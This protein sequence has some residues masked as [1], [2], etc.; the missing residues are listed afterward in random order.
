MPG[1]ALRIYIYIIHIERNKKV[2][3]YTYIT[4]IL[5]IYITYINVLHTKRGIGRYFNTFNHGCSKQL[6]QRKY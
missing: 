4:Y 6:Q 2:Y 1:N 5:Y 3:I